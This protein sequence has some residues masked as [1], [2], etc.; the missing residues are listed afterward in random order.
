MQQ[1]SP[2]AYTLASVLLVGLASIVSAHGHDDRTNMNMGETPA[3][4]ADQDAA[5]PQTYFHHGEYAGFMTAHIILMTVSWVFM[6]P[7]GE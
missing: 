5:G 7:V 6:L 4:M 1:L 3:A 2:G